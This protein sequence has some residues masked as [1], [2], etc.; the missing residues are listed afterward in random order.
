MSVLADHLSLQLRFYAVSVRGQL[1]YRGSFVMSFLASVIATGVEFLGLWALFARFGPL[2]GWTLAEAALLY[3]I[4]NAAF[5]VADL[6]AGSL[7]RFG[8]EFVRTGDYDRLLLRPRPSLL[9]LMGTDFQLRRLGRLAQAL[10]VLGWALSVVG[11][12]LDLAAVAVLAFAVLGGIALFTGLLFA[13]AALGFWTV[14]TLEVGNVLTYGGAQTVQYPLPIYHRFLRRFFTVLVPLACV[15]YFPVVHALDLTDPLGSP[16]L[17]Q[18][19]APLAGFA[20]LLA[21][22]ALWRLGERRYASTGS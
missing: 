18:V 10:V 17:A 3:G 20:F 11:V 22:L 6:L 21:T 15:S 13:H 1:Q 14:E 2:E 5:A 16:P 4:V 12:D 8:S 9:Q 7:E 19:L